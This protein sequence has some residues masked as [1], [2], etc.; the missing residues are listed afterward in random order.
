MDFDKLAKPFLK[1]IRPYKPGRPIEEVQREKGTRMSFVK[2]AS[3]ENPNPP[4]DEVRNAIIDM[5]SQVNRYPESGCYD[6]VKK[7][8]EVHQVDNEEIFVGNGSNEIIDLLTRAFVFPDE[9][10]VYPWPSF[11]IYKLISIQCDIEG[12]QVPCRDH[13]LDLRA[14]ADAIDDK[15]KIVFICNPNNQTSTYL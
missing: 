2:L 15:T 8:A 5:L 9:N 13:K 12:R 4:H 1:E 14:M 10:I 3:N 6:L 11:I 7:L